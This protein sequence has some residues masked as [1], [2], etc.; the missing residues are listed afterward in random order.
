MVRQTAPTSARPD[1]SLA[2]IFHPQFV[3]LDLYPAIRHT[4]RPGEPLEDLTCP[5]VA[6]G[7][8]NSS[9]SAKGR[10]FQPPE[11]RT[12]PL[13]KFCDSKGPAGI[14]LSVSD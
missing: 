12:C 1:L 13:Q 2:E 8:V 11:T 6:A 4:S 3:I 10:K 14:N 7:G 9:E 5:L